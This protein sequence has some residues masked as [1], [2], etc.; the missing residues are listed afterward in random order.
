[1]RNHNHNRDDY[2]YDC[3]III[4]IIIFNKIHQNIDGVALLLRCACKAVRSSEAAVA[5]QRPEDWGVHSCA[6]EIAGY[7]CD[8]ARERTVWD[9]P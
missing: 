3:I 4:V 6:A 8:N 9:W 1:M 2:Y 7:H 5:R